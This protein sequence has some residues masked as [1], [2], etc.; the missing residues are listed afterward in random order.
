MDI[1]TIIGVVVGLGLVLVSIILKSPITAFIDVSS[2]LIVVGGTLAATMVAFS[3]KSVMTAIKASLQI[4]FQQKINYAAT[5]RE[6]LAAAD[7]ARREGALGLEKLSTKS[8]YMK[9][10]YTLVADGYKT[11]DVRD[12]MTIELEAAASHREEV[13]AVLEKMA[14]LAPAWGM[15]GTLIG[16]VIMLLNL[17]DPQ[18]IGPAMAVALLTTLYGALWANLLL[19]PAATKLTERSEKETHNYRLILEGTLG[20]ARNENPR[21]IQQRL[22]GF[23][24][25]EDRAALQAKALAQKKG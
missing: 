24:P 10:G 14:E 20:I 3:I 23:M 21:A 25:P 19:T 5:V 17:D 15:I 12:V 22:V 11:E 6:L 1:G 16:L 2:V 4:F 7:V 9:T 13:V 18:S 8:S